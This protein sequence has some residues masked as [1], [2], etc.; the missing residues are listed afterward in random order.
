MVVMHADGQANMRQTWENYT[1]LSYR[2]SSLMSIE[3][4]PELFGLPQGP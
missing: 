4:H 2:C 3:R 1:L